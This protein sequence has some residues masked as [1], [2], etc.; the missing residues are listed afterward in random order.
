MPTQDPFSVFVHKAID[1]LTY[2]SM[3]QEGDLCT[4]ITELHK[5]TSGEHG[6]PWRGSGFKQQYQV[7]LLG[8]GRC[9]LFRMMGVAVCFNYVPSAET[10]PFQSVHI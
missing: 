6:T 5:A 4:K 9:A 7:S 8:G 10:G 2:D 3:V 1:E